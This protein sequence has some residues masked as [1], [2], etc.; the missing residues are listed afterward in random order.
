MVAR[1]LH[2]V[3]FVVHCL[4]VLFEVSSCAEFCYTDGRYSL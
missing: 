2:N 1:T 4:P 3:N